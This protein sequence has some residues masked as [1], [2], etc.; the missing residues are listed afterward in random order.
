MIYNGGS[1]RAGVSKPSILDARPKSNSWESFLPRLWSSGLFLYLTMQLIICY[2]ITLY[3]SLPVWRPKDI[4][5]ITF[6]EWTARTTPRSY[7][8]RICRMDTAWEHYVQTV[9]IPL[10]SAVC[11]SPAED[12]MIHPVEEVLGECL[13]ICGVK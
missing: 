13:I 3:H 5:D 1:G 4:P 9:L 8:A 6:A 7:L 11:T 10:V 2:L 12:V